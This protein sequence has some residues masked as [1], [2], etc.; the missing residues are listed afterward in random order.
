[1]EVY[2]QVTV[3]VLILLL[4]R[5]ETATTGG[6]ETVFDQELFGLDPYI[7]LAISISWSLLSCVRTHTNL[8]AIEKGFCNITT[9]IIIFF[10]GIFSTLRRILSIIAMF[11]PSLGLFS[12]LHH[13]RWE[14]L[15]FS[16]RLEYSKRCFMS[17]KDKI[18][19]YGLNETIYWSELDHWHYYDNHQDP[20]P[21]SYS[22]YTLFS[23]QTT[24]IAGAVLMAIQFLL[25]TAAKIVTSPEFRRKGHYVNKII[26]VL[27]N[28]NYAI[29]FCDWDE[30]DHTIQE[31]KARFRA[32]CKE[33]TATLCV[34]II[35][36]LVMLVP[37]WYTGKKQLIFV[38]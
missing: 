24:F 21:P 36:T 18:S 22:I 9:K 35:S 37:L 17:S 3:Q 30:G 19:L 38:E 28:L 26:H 4:A 29:P 5:T 8:I 23:L 33:M 1:M 27:E 15:P 7:L 32:T 34:N 11:I 13:W 25:I 2:V 20:A 12:I 10:W 16:T 14:Q 31:F 6:L